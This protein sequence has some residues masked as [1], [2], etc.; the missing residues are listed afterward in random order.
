MLSG[1]GYSDFPS[2]AGFGFPNL[3]QTKPV[4]LVT[5]S[6]PPMY[7]DNY[8]F[9]LSGDGRAK[10][11]GI[12]WVYCTRTLCANSKW[13]GLCG[14]CKDSMNSVRTGQGHCIQHAFLHT[15]YFCSIWVQFSIL[16]VA[17]IN[18]KCV[19]HMWM[20]RKFEGFLS[21]WDIFLSPVIVLD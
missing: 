11:E 14:L 1:G 21:S 18:E 7:N 5:L 10:R 17:M 9:L 12:R 3:C 2:P 6:L 4:S 15:W 16:T 8:F 20:L 13:L 19:L